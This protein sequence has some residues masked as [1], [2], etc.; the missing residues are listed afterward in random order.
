MPAHGRAQA[1]RQRVPWSTGGGVG[2]DHAAAPDATTPAAATV[3]SEVPSDAVPPIRAANLKLDQLRR[4]EKDLLRSI[5][6]CSPL[7]KAV[8]Q[9]KLNEVREQIKAELGARTELLPG[10]RQVRIALNAL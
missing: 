8:L 1:P 4:D 6:G 2:G 3:S 7:G 5:N 10:A 9:E